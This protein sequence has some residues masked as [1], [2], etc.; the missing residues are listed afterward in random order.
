[1][2][3]ITVVKTEKLGTMPPEEQLGF[4]EYFTDHMFTMDYDPEKGWNNPRVA[5]YNEF[6]LFPAAM[7]YHYGQ[8]I[9]EGIKAFRTA[10]NRVVVFR[11]KDYLRRFNRSADALC[12]PPIDV[13]LVAA[14]LNKVVETDKKWVP[15]KVEAAFIEKER[16][17]TIDSI[18]RKFVFFKNLHKKNSLPES[19][20]EKNC[21][22]G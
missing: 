3:E 22:R 17:Y 8:A 6:S 7:V 4:G 11:P 13:D 19:P 2:T 21:N 12:I 18:Q 15:Q 1:M 14:G 10:D 9:F 5:P 16:T 20:G